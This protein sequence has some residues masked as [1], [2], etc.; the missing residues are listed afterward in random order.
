MAAHRAPMPEITFRGVVE[1]DWIDV[2]GHMNVSWYDHVFD[3]AE[4]TFFAR[5]GVDDGSI[6]T[7]G[8]TLFRLEKLVRYET[9]LLLAA[10]IE[11]HSRLV[12]SDYRRLHHQHELVASAEGRRAA[13]VDA[14]SIHV[15]LSARRSVPVVSAQ[16]RASIEALLQANA[17]L[18]P[19]YGIP[20]RDDRHRFGG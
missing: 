2:N 7:S 12:W 4:T 8:H 5:M 3:Q 18:P 13:F 1:R 9:E 19:A 10:P 11:V 15:D 6:A 16:V 17:A 14:M 20:A